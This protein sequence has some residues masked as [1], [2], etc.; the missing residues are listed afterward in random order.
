MAEL[1]KEPNEDLIIA[2]SQ[3]LLKNGMKSTT[4][5]SVASALSM[6]KRT[7]YE[8]FESKKDM[9]IR[10][11]SYWQQQRRETIENIFTSSKTVMEA[12]VRTFAYHKKLMTEVNVEFFFDMDQNYPEVRE[13]F[14]EH[15]FLWIDKLMYA[16]NMGIDQGVFRPDVNYPI[17]LRMMRV[18]M[19]SLKRMEELFPEGIEL[20]DA[21][22]SISISFLR[23]I[24][25]Q[26]GMEIIDNFYL[27]NQ[28]YSNSLITE[29]V[30]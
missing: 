18:Q 9:I 27:Q 12:L 7:L 5:D 17:V 25:S 3:I 19:E 30:S 29:D 11:V 14:N 8:I 10:A 4:M 28:K 13:L 1:T 22:D 16:I 6:S 15:S 26:E 21:F 23:S 2:I 24:A 20:T